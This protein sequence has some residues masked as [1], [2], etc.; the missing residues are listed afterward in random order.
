[1]SY[2][3]IK[4]SYHF[5]PFITFLILIHRD[6]ISTW[7]SGTGGAGVIGALSYAFLKSWFPVRTTLQLMLVVPAIEAASFW[8]VLVRPP[9]S[10][11]VGKLNTDSQL[12][13]VDP[14][15]KTIKEKFS[16]VPSL[17][18]YMIPVGLVYFFEYFINQGL[19]SSEK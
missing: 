15:K 3:F 16:L 4:T 13:M 2:N 12:Q 9:R 19:V 18:K 17:L 7:S 6:V 11:Q 10:S 14:P 5:I 8:L 1:M